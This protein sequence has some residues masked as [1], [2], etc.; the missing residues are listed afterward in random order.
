MRLARNIAWNAVGILLPL[1]VGVVV[2]PAIVRGLGTERFGFLSIVWMMIGYFSIFDFGLGRALTKL[3]ADR[4]GDGREGEVAALTA[5]SL[6]LVLGTSVVLAAGLALSAGWIAH[7]AMGA[8]PE[9]IPEATAAI[10]WLAASLPF[11]LLATVLAGLL[12]AYQR[13][14]MLSAVRLPMGI[15]VLAAPLAVLPWTRDLGVLTAVVGALRVANLAALGWMTLRV[16]PA[17]RH[18]VLHFRR[19]WVRPLLTFGGWLTIS[20]LVSPLMLYFDRFI[21]AA[22]LGSAAIAFYTV[23][24]DVLNRLLYIPQ[25]IQSVLFPNFAMLRVQN[26]PRVMTVFSR[27]SLATLALMSP[28]LFA[29]M[30]LAYPALNLWVGQSFAQHGTLVAKTLMVGVLVNAMART[31]FVFVQ[32]VGYAKWTAVLHMLE[33]P[34]YATSLWM[35]LHGDLGIEGAALAWSGRMVVDTVA[36]YAMTARLEPRLWATVVRDLV[37]TAAVCLSAVALSRSFS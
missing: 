31:P 14:V 16:V 24:Y 30:L 27:G 18:E 34:I 1:A 19:E 25:A 2:V 10:L 3:A 4:L 21:I 22:V 13:F 12:E 8:S 5:T 9:L 33:L 23:P 28:A 35:L 7:R 32:G 6:I 15:L 36:L 37:L 11:V 26:S 17:L 20:N 29:V